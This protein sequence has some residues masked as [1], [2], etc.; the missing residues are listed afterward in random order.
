MRAKGNGA[1]V[2]VHGDKILVT[3]GGLGAL[4]RQAARIYREGP[5]VLLQAMEGPSRNVLLAALS[6]NRELALALVR[7]L[8]EK[9]VSSPEPSEPVPDSD[10]ARL[11]GLLQDAFRNNRSALTAALQDNNEL[12]VSWLK[13]HKE[14]FGI[15]LKG[16]VHLFVEDVTS[17]KAVDIRDG[18][19]RLTL[20][21]SG[22][23]D[24]IHV[25]YET[26]SEQ[27]FSKVI[28]AIG[29]TPGG[30]V[31]Q[32]TDTRADTKVCPMCAEE[33]KAAAIV[34]RFCGHKF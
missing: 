6:E 17:A 27:E 29:K 18:K 24:D 19:R 33:V 31:Q 12:V 16:D 32:A 7:S 20:E 23:H 26:S 8:R 2:A 10:R 3:H 11:I 4:L 21:T 5:T 13:N 28:D 1:E 30:S 9:G 14:L 22:S 25:E 15:F 34:C